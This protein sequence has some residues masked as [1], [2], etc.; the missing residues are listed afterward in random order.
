VTLNNDA[1]DIFTIK[2]TYPSGNSVIR[3]Y[4]L[5]CKKAWMMVVASAQFNAEGKVTSINAKPTKMDVASK[6]GI[7]GEKVFEKVCD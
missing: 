7:E 6:F 2:A 4:E 3:D 5:Y 1:G